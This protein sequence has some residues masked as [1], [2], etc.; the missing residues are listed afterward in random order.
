MKQKSTF[1]TICGGLALKQ[2]ILGSDIPVDVADFQDKF[3]N[4]AEGCFGSSSS[5]GKKKTVSY[6]S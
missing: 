2:I 3:T 6:M 1:E 5:L 4:E